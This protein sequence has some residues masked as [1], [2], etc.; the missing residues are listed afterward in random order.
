[1]GRSAPGRSSLGAIHEIRVCINLTTA[2][3]FSLTVK[4]TPIEAAD[5]VIE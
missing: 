1:M 5:E 3:A 4:P 2:T